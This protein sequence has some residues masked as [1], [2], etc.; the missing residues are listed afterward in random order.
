MDVHTNSCLYC[1]TPFGAKMNQTVVSPLG[2]TKKSILS[3]IS[4]FGK[5]EWS[6]TEVV[7]EI[8]FVPISL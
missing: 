8:M 7:G 3:R 2:V 4:S 5:E 1:F 6:K